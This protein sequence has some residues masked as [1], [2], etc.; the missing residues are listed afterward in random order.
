[1]LPSHPIPA[2]GPRAP[3]RPQ[4]QL[5]VTCKDLNRL[6]LRGAAFGPAALGAAF[7]LLTTAQAQTPAT[8]SC[9]ASLGSPSPSNAEDLRQ[10][11]QQLLGQ[12]AVCDLRADYH[13]LLGALWLQSGQHS[14]AAD[15]LE[16]SLLLNPEQPGTQLDYAHALAL[17]GAKDSAQHIVNQ[18][19]ARP[20]I[21]PDLRQW[22]LGNA[23]QRPEAAA[24]WTWAQLLQT[25]LGHE[26]NLASTTHANAITLYLSNGPVSVPLA[27]GTR[28]QSGAALK[29][30]LAIQG[31]SP[32]GSPDLRLSLALQ[33]RNA[34]SLASNQM[35][36][37]S[38]TYSRALGP[39]LAQL[40]WDTQHY[41]SR[42][43]NNFHDQ[44]LSLYYQFVPLPAPCM[45]RIGVASTE[46]TY[47]ASTNFDGRYTQ[48]RLEG[49]CKHPDRTETHLA[50]GAGHDRAASSQR[51][52]GDKTRRD[53]TLRHD[54]P[55]GKAAT[56][57]WLK[58]TQLSDAEQFSPLLG[59]L[60]SRSTR[61]DWGVGA[62]WPLGAQ[63]K[64]GFD[65]E[66]TSQKSSNVLLNIKNLSI[67]GG[68]RWTGP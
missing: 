54:R 56:Q 25:T 40:R 29:N 52:G 24:Q 3:A 48:A 11:L 6:A 64:L 5:A 45:W 49:S 58:Q 35:L 36:A 9:P 50:L 31:Q 51:P 46:Q 15:A 55:I 23:T 43:T 22:L 44:G 1:M 13:A 42:N 18:V 7:C 38:V 47:A 39:G 2:S 14:N 63:W 32:A 30:L 19:S 60:V 53:W 17:L 33:T 26:T 20:D 28:P 59:D 65:V 37:A 8:A 68:L 57:A 4:V 66:S 12:A 67:Y 10:R 62:W 27:D 21:D 41:L 16:K 61:T 34:A